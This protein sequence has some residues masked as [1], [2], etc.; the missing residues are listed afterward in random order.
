MTEGIVFARGDHIWG[1][2]NKAMLFIHF[3][4]AGLDEL[5]LWLADFSQSETAGTISGFSVSSILYTQRERE[6]ERERERSHT[7]FGV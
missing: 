1:G 2:G 6:R 3:R 7:R 4:A 5:P